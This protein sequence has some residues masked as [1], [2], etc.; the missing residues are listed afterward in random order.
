MLPGP[1]DSRW[2]A[3]VDDPNRY[4]FSFLALRILMQRISRRSP[5]SPAERTAAID[6]VYA[7]FKKNER[8]IAADITAVFG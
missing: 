1:N 6:E 2:G 5:L 7:C 3:I 4:S 8:L